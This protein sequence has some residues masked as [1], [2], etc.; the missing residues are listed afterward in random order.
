MI[1][2][3]TYIIIAVT[4]LVSIPAFNNRQI[5]DKF[6]FNPFRIINLGEHYRLLSSGFIHAD[7]M[8][9]LFNMYSFYMFA[10]I[11][12]TTILGPHKMVI[13]YLLSILGGSFF[14]LAVHHNHDH[15][16]ALGASGGVCGIVFSFVAM[17]PTWGIGII[18]IP[19][20]IPGWIFA[21][22][23]VAYSSIG[24]KSQ[25]S[26]IGHDAHLGGAFSGLVITAILF[27][28]KIYANLPYIAAI[29]IFSLAIF[30]FSSRKDNFS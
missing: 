11:L 23:F 8:H 14:S 25:N 2:K 1:P 20:F 13:V 4:C 22:L 12:E 18:F 6:I 5:I 21:I 10:P 19:I 16:R 7:V 30:Y 17:D 15:Y 9:L 3:V 24:M 26:R 29:I 28:Q 27:P